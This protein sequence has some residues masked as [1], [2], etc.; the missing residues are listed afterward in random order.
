MDYLAKTFRAD[1]ILRLLT[2]L[3]YLQGSFRL[4]VTVISAGSHVRMACKSTEGP[5]CEGW[6]HWKGTIVS[7]GRNDTL[8]PKLLM[9]TF[10][11]GSTVRL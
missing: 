11:E 8:I 6:S 9:W 4:C 10:G 7:T 1:K 3:P 5:R 2:S